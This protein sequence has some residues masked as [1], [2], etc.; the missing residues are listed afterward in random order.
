VSVLLGCIADDFTGAT[1]IASVLKR[2]GMRVLQINGNPSEKALKLQDVDAIVVAL[3]SRTQPINDAV[4]D[5]LSACDWLLEQGVKQIFFKYCSTFDSTKKGNIGPV[6][7]ALLTRLKT[8]KTIVC[9]SYPING[10]TVYGSNLFVNGVPLAESAMKDHPL[11][12]MNDSNLVRLLSSQVSTEINIKSVSWQQV[13]LGVKALEA[14]FETT[15][16]SLWVVDALTDDDLISIAHAAKS[17]TLLTGGAALAQG[18]PDLYRQLNW[19]KNQQDTNKV[20]FPKGHTLILAGSCSTATRAQ[21]ACFLQSNL[22]VAV[23]PI[24]LSKNDDEFQR[25]ENFVSS[26]IGKSPILVYASDTP[27]NISKVQR[28]LGVEKAG[29]LVEECLSRLAVKGVTE[30][31]VSK[32]IVAGGETSG[33]ITS[34]LEASV[35]LIDDEIEPGVPWTFI[36][37]EKTVA[38]AL[39]SGNFGSETFFLKAF[40]MTERDTV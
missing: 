37:G 13:Q 7:E 28:E 17:M 24:A 5:S 25:L 33:A 2:N 40:E 8:N 35:L 1:D 6:I 30:Y 26:N 16:D 10:R 31:G 29:K 23:D 20:A 14:E 15:E 12:P 19:M 18:L 34:A 22:G 9:P 27:E 4:E 39:K 21:V 36:Q 32:I 3:K 38:L 11:T